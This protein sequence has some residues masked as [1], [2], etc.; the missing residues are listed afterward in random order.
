MS[1]WFSISLAALAL[2]FLKFVATTVYRLTLHPLAKIP[3]P[4]LAAATWWY[5][6]YFDLYL[7]AQFFKQIGKLHEQYGPIVRINPNEVHVNDPDL[8]D[9]VYPGGYKKVNKDPYLMSQ[10]GMLHNTSFLSIDHDEHRL[11]RNALNRYF[12]KAAV[13][14]LEDYIKQTCERFADKLLEYRNTGPLTISAAYSSF[15]TDVIAEYCFGRTFNFLGRDRFLPNLQAAN[16]AMGAM[17]PVLRLFPWLHTVMRWIPQERMLKMN[18]GMADWIGMENICKKSVQDARARLNDEKISKG[19][20]NVIDELLRSNLPE[21]EKTDERL[22]LE[23]T[24]LVNAATETT[25]WALS[26]CTFYIY[27]NREI[28]R[29]MR[30]ELLAVAPDRNVPPLA[31]LEALPYLSAVIMET[32]RHQ[33]GPVSRLPRIFPV[34]ATHLHSTY[35]GK[36]VDYVIPP[37]YVLSMTSI[38]IHMNPDLFPNP[39]AFLPERWL[40]GQGQRNREKEKYLLTFS[41]GTRICLGMNLAYAELYLCL[42]AVI[43]RVGENIELFETTIKDVTPEYDA[44]AMRPYKESKGIRVIIT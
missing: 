7:G 32:L 43:L 2:L 40:D 21:Q 34:E 20:Y 37:G 30:S 42:A 1:L 36:P 29:K 23:A 33:F 28:M 13:A 22:L 10:F 41:K 17:I 16:D 3:G 18:P 38:Y 15:T 6:R 31:K 24:V 39:H 26:L 5:E 14:K 8:I 11:R 9:T 27:H 19:Y 25:A 4:K 35:K 44:F 12:S